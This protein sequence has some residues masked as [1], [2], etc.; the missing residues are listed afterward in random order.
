MKTTCSLL[1]VVILCCGASGEDLR[2]LRDKAGPPPAKLIYAQL[3]QQAYAAFDRREKSLE[4][5]ETPEQILAYQAKLKQFFEDQLG[6]FPE[7]TPLNAQVVGK[8]G[9]DGYRV[10]KLIFESRLHHHVTAV[11]YLPDGPG[12]FPGVAVSSGHSRT[13]KTAEYN[14]RFGI[15]LAM[16]GIAALCYD[17]IGQGERSQILNDQGQPRFTGTVHEHTLVGIGS[18]LVG[19]NTASYRTWDGIRAIDYLVSRSDIDDQRLGFTGC[20][21]GGTLTSYVMA[22]DDRV[23][24]AA[25]ACYLTTF[26]R[27]IETIGPQDAEQNIYGQIAFGL[28]QPDYVLMRAPRPT[29]ISST[30][31]DFLDIGGSWDS[32]RQ[33]KRLYWRLGYPERVDLV[34]GAGGHGVPRQNLTAIVRWMRRWLLDKDDAF[35]LPEIS[36]RSMEDLLCTKKGQVLTLPDEKSVFD[37]NAK[38][39]QSLAEKRRTYW[40]QTPPE[41]VL[42]AVRQTVGVRGIDEIGKLRMEKVGR[43]QRNGYHIDK[44]VLH[45]PSGVP[46]PALTFHP[47]DPKADAYLYLHEGGKQADAAVGGPIEKL[48][49]KGR[50]V[51]AVDL[52]GFGETA[53]DENDKTLGYRFSEQTFFL[54]YLLKQSI[55]G[56]RTEDTLACG[57]WVANY[58]TDKPRNVHLVGIGSAGLAALHAAALEPELFLPR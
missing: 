7:R 25:P 18:I 51:V 19:R 33:A 50:V 23:L 6:G 22:L 41:D 44:L 26:R 10:E 37:L 20:S 8:Q 11:L 1:V 38:F 16:G 39:A 42:R 45:T 12:P 43:L 30:T 40:Q 17:P 49:S 24:C 46:I 5:L 15:A 34:E 48:V 36:V 14:Q 54:A 58:E 56:L 4:E 55:V 2:C 28:D 13:A 3:Q 57:R 52:R 32:Y 35:V 21:G 47:P 9:G 27:L 31:G 53:P 29:L